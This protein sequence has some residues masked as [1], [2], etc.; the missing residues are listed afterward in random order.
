MLRLFDPTQQFQDRSGALLVGGCIFVYI[1]GTDDLAIV[2]NG[3]GQIMAQPML[4]DSNGRVDGVF[5]DETKTY[6]MVV[7][8]PNGET[9]FTITGMKPSATAGSVDVTLEKFVRVDAA[10]VFTDA[11]KARAR[12]NIGAQAGPAV[13]YIGW[14]GTDQIWTAVDGV[15]NAGKTPVLKFAGYDWW[16]IDLTDDG[17]YVF[18]TSVGEG[19][20]FGYAQI[21]KNTSPLYKFRPCAALAIYDYSATNHFSQMKQSLQAGYMVRLRYSKDGTHYYADVNRWTYDSESQIETIIFNFNPSVPDEGFSRIY[22][23]LYTENYV[24]ASRNNGEDL[25]IYAPISGYVKT[26]EIP[27]QSE[28]GDDSYKSLGYCGFINF[29]VFYHQKAYTFGSCFVLRIKSSVAGDPR[30]ELPVSDATIYYPQRIYNGAPVSS[31]MDTV[32]QSGGYIG[33]GDVYSEVMF[34]IGV[35]SG[36][37]QW[38]TSDQEYFTA[39]GWFRVTYG[40]RYWDYHYHLDKCNSS[41]NLFYK[42]ELLRTGALSA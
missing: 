39:D 42:I 27:D 1:D 25:P 12:E 33:D 13:E 14:N 28:T 21:F 36:G 10:Q 20:T 37:D 34:T 11:E 17:R 8:A 15:K 31:F 23:V 5:V 26:S 18:M 2:R 19:N 32:T 9:L 6:R 40:G 30:I 3:N 24:T 4:I 16:P 35:N 29:G 41:D 38:Q 22:E 7:N